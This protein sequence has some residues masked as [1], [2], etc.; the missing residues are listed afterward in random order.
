MAAFSTIVTAVGVGVSVVGKVNERKAQKEQT[1]AIERQAVE[2]RRQAELEQRRADIQNAR[3]IRMAMRQARIARASVVNTGANAGTLGSSGVLGGVASI[4][5]QFEA[6]RSFMGQMGQI[7]DATTESQAR[8]GVAVG[9]QAVAGAEG[10][11][12]GALG[13]LGGTIF[14]AGGGF[15]T[16]FDAVNK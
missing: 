6:N 7:S 12:W 8:A 9:E 14:E 10:A 16:I 13:Q 3:Q 4:G 1:Q 5:S 11:A 15:K 2:V